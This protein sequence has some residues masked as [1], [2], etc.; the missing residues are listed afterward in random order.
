MMTAQVTWAELWTVVAA[1]VFL[2]SI[3]VGVVGWLWTKFTQHDRELGEFKI[4]VAENYVTL[5]ALER[6]ENRFEEAMEKLG[7]RI[8]KMMDRMTHLSGGGH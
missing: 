6:L 8:E 2:G 5:A 7:G 1:I 3:V 4:K